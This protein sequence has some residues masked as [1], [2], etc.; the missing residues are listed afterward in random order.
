M[1]TADA[2]SHLVDDATVVYII[3]THRQAASHSGFVRG[4][5][6]TPLW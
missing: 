1:P 3:E 6:Q 5:H 4:E 2:L